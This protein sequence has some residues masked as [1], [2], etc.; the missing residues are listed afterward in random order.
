MRRFMIPRIHQGWPECDSFSGP[1]SMK[2]CIHI[3]VEARSRRSG[4]SLTG[5]EGCPSSMWATNHCQADQPDQP[6][7]RQH[8]LSHETGPSIPS[9]QPHSRTYLI[10]L[11]I[12]GCLQILMGPSCLVAQ[13]KAPDAGFGLLAH[14]PFDENYSSSVNNDLYEGGRRGAFTS[15]HKDKQVAKVGAG[16]LR[17]D[18]GRASGRGL[19]RGSQPTLWRS[20]RRVHR[21]R[22]VSARI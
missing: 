13:K 19:C 2:G 18:S 15:I 4:R 3:G 5:I 8:C 11:C 16:A 20:Q 9:F 7:L 14:W 1:L 22:L 21:R 12:G 10:A 6:D 17:L